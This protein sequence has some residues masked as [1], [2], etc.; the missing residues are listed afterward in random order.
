MFLHIICMF[1]I[2]IT[3]FCNLDHGQHTK[4]ARLI[5]FSIL[6]LIFLFQSV[7]NLQLVNNTGLNWC[8]NR[9]VHWDS[10]LPLCLSSKMPNADYQLTTWTMKF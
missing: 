4:N 8:L 2:S 1:L 3:I 6:R 10:V 7:A 5:T 9:L